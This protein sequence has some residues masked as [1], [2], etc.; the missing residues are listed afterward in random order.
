[1]PLPPKCSIEDCIREAVR[2][3][4]CNRHYLNGKARDVALPESATVTPEALPD[5]KAVSPWEWQ[6]WDSKLASMR[7][8]PTISINRAGHI[9]VSAAADAMI[10]SPEY[11]DVY[12]SAHPQGIGFKAGTK[13]EG[14]KVSR[15]KGTGG[16]T[17]S[18]V[19]FF[20]HHR[21]DY[22][23]TRRWRAQ[24]IDGVLAINL[25]DAPLRA[26]GRKAGVHG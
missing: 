4:L 8:S 15:S 21:I 13:E 18:A 26:M 6:R 7:G 20:E 23:E 19:R 16:F 24:L 9:A 3:G 11:V 17:L 2:D 1:M 22:S 25:D 14:L 5:A 12:Y 10:G